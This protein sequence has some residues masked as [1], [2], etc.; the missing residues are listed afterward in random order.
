VAISNVKFAHLNG[1][2]SG[3][4]AQALHVVGAN[5][6]AVLLNTSTTKIEVYKSTNG[7][8]SWTVQDS[9]NSLTH[10]G[11]THSYTSAM[12]PSG[13]S[14][15]LIHV[16]YRTATNTVRVRRFN[17]STDT[18]ESAD[19]PSGASATTIAHT[20]FNLTMGVRSDGDVLLYWRGSISNDSTAAQWQGASWGAPGVVFA[21][22][23]SYPLGT[24]VTGNSDQ[25]MTTIFVQTNNDIFLEPLNNANT[26]GTQVAMDATITQMYGM[27]SAYVNDGGT[28]RMGSIARDADGS[29]EFIHHS[30]LTNVP[31]AGTAVTAV[32]PTTTTDPGIMGGCVVAYNNK[33]H[34]IWSGDA[35]GSIHMDISDDYATPAFST[36][37]NVVT[38]L[39]NDPALNAQAASTGVVVL[40]QN[41]TGPAVD[42]IWAVGSF[43]TDVTVNA[44]TATGTGAALAATVTYDRS[45]SGEVAS[46][47]GTAFAPTLNLGGGG[48]ADWSLVATGTLEDTN[49]AIDRSPEIPAGIATGDIGIM[50]MAYRD[51]IDITTVPTGWTLVPGT[52]IDSTTDSRV[53]A[54]YKVLDSS[55]GG[56]SPVWSAASALTTLSRI[57]VFRSTTGVHASPID[58]NAVDRTFDAISGDLGTITP[59]NDDALVIAIVGCDEEIVG[60]DR[61]TWP[62]GWTEIVDDTGT[63]NVWLGAAWREQATAGGFSGGT[64]TAEASDAHAVAVFGIRPVAGA[65]G[66]SVNAVT[67][68]GTGQ[69]FAPTI[70]YDRS[71]T[72]VT[73]TGT[74]AAL[75]ATVTYPR[76]VTGEVS[77]GT[78]QAFAATVTYERN[79]SAVTATGTGTAL[80]PTVTYPRTVTGELA[81]AIGDALAA[82]ITISRS[83]LAVTATGTGDALAAT[84]TYPRTVFGELAT[85]TGSALVPTVEITGANTTVNAVAATATGEAF[86]ATITYPRTVTGV[87]ATGSGQAFAATITYPRTVTAALAT[88]TGAA[89][90]ATVTY[91]RTV[92]AVTATGT[93]QAYAATPF[94]AATN[95]ITGTSLFSFALGGSALRPVP[96]VL[97]PGASVI[98]SALGGGSAIVPPTGGASYTSPSLAGGSFVEST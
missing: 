95:T 69:A 26:R 9:A 61:Y 44:V 68:T 46:G 88:G 59:V 87:L 52:P 72:A 53:I 18:W 35:R 60:T 62:A 91:A 25:A 4:V 81:T 77:T 49:N 90:A 47:T 17:T 27:I 92:T 76:T 30:G 57:S 43:S 45:V 1:T 94:A 20:D 73:A 78:G 51:Q 31:G 97:L 71:V 39:A 15:H 42:L 21:T 86:P 10:T 14:M 34:L 79:V 7:G 89:F 83:V 67:A 70:T 32:S 82:T 28:H 24:L 50:Y 98:S 58:F 96:V 74:G 75:A 22:Q 38:G 13:A 33:W 40:Y 55:E 85:A 8:T 48:S 54:Y 29:L 23:T 64:L 36:D 6:Y 84:V 56:T 63:S 37:T 66:V 41:H 5:L 93:G 3:W 16:A 2:T 11:T 65:A 19:V 12:P 80:A